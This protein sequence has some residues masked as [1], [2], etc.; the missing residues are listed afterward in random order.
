MFPNVHVRTNAFMMRTPL[1]RQ[2]LGRL[3]IKTKRDAHHAEH[4][5]NSLTR[6][7]VSQA[8]R[9][10]CRS[11]WPRL[12]PRMVEQQPNV[13]PGESGQPACRRQPDAS[14]G[15][16]TW[17]ERQILYEATWGAVRAPGPPFG[18]PRS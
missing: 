1:A 7:V 4:G 10:D 15:R 3:V 13:P 16:M 12:C 11:Q 2:T 8:S 14:L 17:P 6:Q 9:L 5:P 18:N